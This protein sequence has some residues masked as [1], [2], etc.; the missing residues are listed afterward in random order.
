M[1]P[2]RVRRSGEFASKEGACHIVA[3]S[4][5]GGFRRG[6]CPAFLIERGSPEPHHATH[7]TTNSEKYTCSAKVS[8]SILL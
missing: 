3:L 6:H 4:Q 5:N 8:P 1:G 2:A 7:C